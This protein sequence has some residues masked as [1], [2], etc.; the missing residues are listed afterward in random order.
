MSEAGNL[1]ISGGGEIVIHVDEEIG[2][3][4]CCLITISGPLFSP[5]KKML[6]R[7]IDE[8]S[9]SPNPWRIVVDYWNSGLHF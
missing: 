2:F 4:M 3:F 5:L 6:E 7:E 8:G 9:K 1:E